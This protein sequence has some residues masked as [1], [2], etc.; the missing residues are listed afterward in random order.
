MD[1]LLDTGLGTDA[2][3]QIGV[4]VYGWGTN[5]NASKITPYQRISSFLRPKAGY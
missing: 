3:Q 2:N 1:E 5:G 4:T